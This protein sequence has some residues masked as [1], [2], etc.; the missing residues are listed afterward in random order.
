[1]KPRFS[2]ALDDSEAAAQRRGTRA[3][4]WG[5]RIV[6]VRLRFLIVLLV[7]VG[8]VTQWN[9]LANRWD[10]LVDAVR[11]R[12]TNP[13]AGAISSDTEYFCPM[14]P[15][16]IS[17]WP[18]KCSI[19]NMALVRRRKGEAV[20]LPDG[21][22]AR[23]QLSPY[24]VQLAGIRTSPVGYLPLAR[25]V[26][27]QGTVVETAGT[28]GNTALP[29]VKRPPQ[30]ETAAPSVV[31]ID[32]NERE[33]PL[34]ARGQAVELA[35]DTF[36]GR[37]P[38]KGVV[39]SVGPEFL[40]ARRS[41][42]AKVAVVAAHGELWPG[43]RVRARLRRPM[44]EIE[45]FRSQPSDPPPVSAADPRRVFICPDHPQVVELQPGR[46]PHDKNELDERPLADHQRVGWWCPMHP[47]VMAGEPGHECVECNGMT[48][49]AR[50]V[51]F[52]P[53]GKV[54]AV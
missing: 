46:C 20:Q 5:L 3:L 10:W 31:E 8:V 32:L 39:T 4:A 40:S 15:G 54:L 51:N 43:M 28:P 36:P 49:M 6:A 9:A 19:C 33:I 25:E 12:G 21:V 53:A 1:M 41:M 35:S 34:V 7:A 42:V 37:A 24:R 27:A 38:W 45:P 48:L 47:L 13:L 16:V 18:T 29:N 11:H 23:M 52:R 22:V 2:P 30:A 50:V 14:D 26:V 17:D 44:S